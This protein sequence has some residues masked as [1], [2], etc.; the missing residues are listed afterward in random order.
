M[1]LDFKLY[2]KTKVIKMAWNCH[3]DRYIDQWNRIGSPEINPCTNGQLLYVKGG[4]N[5]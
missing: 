5:I 1:L 2:Y 4:K 3:K